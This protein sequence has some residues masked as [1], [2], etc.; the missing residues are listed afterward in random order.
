MVRSR[1]KGKAGFEPHS[2][3][4]VWFEENRQYFGRSYMVPSFWFSLSKCVG[5]WKLLLISHKSWWLI[6]QQEARPSLTIP[7]RCLLMRVI[8]CSV[9]RVP[10]FMAARYQNDSFHSLKTVSTW[11]DWLSMVLRLRQ[12]NIGYTADG[13]YRSDDPTNSV[14][15]LKEGG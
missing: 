13:F 10:R 2:S 15:A 12:H 7:A 6:Y 1:E 11:F 5:C 4:V 3:P 14:K 9:V 8:I